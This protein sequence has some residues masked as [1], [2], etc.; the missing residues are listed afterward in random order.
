MINAEDRNKARIIELPTCEMVTS[1]ICA[2][3]EASSENGRLRRFEKWF[4]KQDALRKDRFYSRD[5]MWWDEKAGGSAWGLAVTDIPE[6]TGGFDIID[7]PG[8]LYAVANFVDDADAPGDVFT[9]V[10]ML[11]A[12]VDNSGCFEADPNR[13]YL[14]HFI[15]TRR[16]AESMGYHQQDIYM[17]IRIREE[18]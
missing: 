18:K 8:G 3:K 6:D 11:N 4:A 16:A 17:P 1:G 2:G 5:F 10:G 14:N 9:V 15:G 7:F 13:N 12:W